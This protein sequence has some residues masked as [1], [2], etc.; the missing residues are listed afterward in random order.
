MLI[1]LREI[2]RSGTVLTYSGFR[3]PH[4]PYLVSDS[5][6]D[7]ARYALINSP[8]VMASRRRVDRARRL[9]SLSSVTS[10]PAFAL[11]APPKMGASS[12]GTKLR[13]VRSSLDVSGVV[14]SGRLARR[15]SNDTPRSGNLLRIARSASSTTSG[16]S[17]SLIFPSLKS[18]MIALEA[19]VG[20]F[21]PLKSA[22][23]SRKTLRGRR[24]FFMPQLFA[25]FSHFC[26][27]VLFGIQ[28]PW[29]LPP[30]TGEEEI[31]FDALNFAI[32]L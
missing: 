26:Q 31:H 10:I 24:V 21:K 9:K 12:V 13:A 27:D 28:P 2:P 1:S 32:K 30:L 6:H 11:S 23:V 16:E 17:M 15:S 5:F 14:I 7:S 8:G 19:P 22:L 20:E 3:S 18:A 25:D 29:R 4:A